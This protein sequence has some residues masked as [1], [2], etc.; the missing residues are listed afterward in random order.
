MQK[1]KKNNRKLGMISVNHSTFELSKL[2]QQHVINQTLANKV[3]F[4]VFAASH[5]HYT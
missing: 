4:V 2:E 3:K 5:S 1:R